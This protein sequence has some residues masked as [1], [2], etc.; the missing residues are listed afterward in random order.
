MVKLTGP[1]MSIDASGTFAKSMVFSKWKGRNYAR[2]HAIPANPNSPAQKGVRALFKFITQDFAGLSAAIKA[3]WQALA[4]NGNITALNAQVRDAQNRAKIGDGW[5]QSP[6][7]AN[8]GGIDA[9]T[10]LTL[11]P[12]NGGLRCS[13][14]APGANPGDYTNALYFGPSTGFAASITT[15]VVVQAVA[16][17][18]VDV[19]GL[20]SGI[21]VFGLVRSTAVGG[22]LGTLS[23]EASGTP[24]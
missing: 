7:G 21:E 20:Q 12:L 19:L 18:T 11:T 14:T 4:A 1:M 15:V 3:E 22:E 17:I 5:R 13:W 24:T 2:R 23:A 9:P 8:P 10:S 6:T 16:T